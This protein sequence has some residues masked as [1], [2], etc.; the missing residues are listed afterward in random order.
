MTVGTVTI[1]G[2]TSGGPTGSRSFVLPISLNSAVDYTNQVTLINGNTTVGVP[3]GATVCLFTPPNAT[4][5]TPNPVY[6]GTITLKGVAGDT[7]IAL[8]TTVPMLLPIASGVTS[9]ILTSTASGTAE[10]WFG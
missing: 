1:S 9:F 4:N 3:T 2:N 7:G 6:G 8:S 10:V 5:P